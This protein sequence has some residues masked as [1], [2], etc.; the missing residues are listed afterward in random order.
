MYL[1]PWGPMKALRTSFL[2]SCISTSTPKCR[3]TTSGVAAEE[4]TA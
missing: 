2:I 1:S 3:G 4:S